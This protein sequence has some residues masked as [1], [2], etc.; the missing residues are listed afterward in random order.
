MGK[1]A[2]Y[3]Q[4]EMGLA[5]AYEHASRV[6]VDNMMA[7]DAREGIDA[8]IAKRKPEWSGH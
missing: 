8:F 3:A 2:F 6:M 4:S 5:G 7:H 1:E